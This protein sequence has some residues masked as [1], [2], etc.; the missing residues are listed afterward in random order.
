MFHVTETK[1]SESSTYI[2]FLSLFYFK[3]W[4][5]NNI[6]HTTSLFMTFTTLSQ[7]VR[8]KGYINTFLGCRWNIQCPK[9]YS[10]LLKTEK[11]AQLGFVW[12]PLPFSLLMVSFV[13]PPPPNTFRTGGKKLGSMQSTNVNQ[14]IITSFTKYFKQNCYEHFSEKC[15]H[16]YENYDTNSNTLLLLVCHMGKKSY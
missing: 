12:S 15:S 7:A 1:Q 16:F 10:D 2:Q 13:H 8:K 14:E 3:V 4:Q 11:R 9:P 5:V 6:L